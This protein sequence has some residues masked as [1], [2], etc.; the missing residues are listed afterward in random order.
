M[1]MVEIE[2]ECSEE[3]NAIEEILAQFYDILEE[4]VKGVYRFSKKVYEFL[5]NDILSM[6]KRLLFGSDP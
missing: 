3:Q 1:A 6:T 4:A 2:V 5:N